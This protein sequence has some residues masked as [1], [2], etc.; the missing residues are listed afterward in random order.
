MAQHQGQVAPGGVARH[1]DVAGAVAQQ[2]QVVPGTK[3]VFH[4]GGIGELRGQ[5][6]FKA[7]HI[8]TR[9]M[10]QLRGQH[11][12]VAQIAAGVP[13][14]VTVENGPAVAVGLFQPGPRSGHSG[15]GELLPIHAGH[16]RGDAAKNL[17]ASA[18]ALQL[19]VVHGV[20]GAGAVQSFQGPH[21][22]I[23]AGT[24]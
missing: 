10:G 21:H 13:P 14:A 6:V 22:R 7:E 24:F 15:Q 16:G 12:G 3:G 19:L 11:T 8:V 2:H 5:P 23:Q 9:G 20:W 1:H 18:L 4:R 17:L